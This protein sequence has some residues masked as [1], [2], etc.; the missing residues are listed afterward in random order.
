MLHIQSYPISGDI[1]QSAKPF[2]YYTST[3][4]TEEPAILP[5]QTQA[6]TRATMSPSTN[7]R[8]YTIESNPQSSTPLPA[9]YCEGKVLS[10]SEL[11]P[12]NELDNIG[13]DPGLDDSPDGM[14]A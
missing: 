10:A 2:F 13:A 11:T 5:F 3:P 4:M 8:V 6:Q 7:N 1:R 12:F 9:P 14:P